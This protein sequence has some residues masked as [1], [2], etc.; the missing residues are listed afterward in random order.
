MHFTR[1]RHCRNTT[2]TLSCRNRV[3]CIVF[4][5]FKQY[6]KRWRRV[7]TSHTRLLGRS[8]IGKIKVFV[9]AHANVDTRDTT[10]AL[11]S[12]AAK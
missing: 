7:E 9:H 1:F 10:I 2:Y 3:K 11:R 12:H 4:Y 8:V 5:G 6:A